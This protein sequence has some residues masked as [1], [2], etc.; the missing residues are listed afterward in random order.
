[1]AGPLPLTI[2]RISSCIASP[3]APISFMA[4]GHKDLA[5]GVTE[6]LEKTVSG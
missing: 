6:G 5:D 3:F 2:L 4:E 1:M